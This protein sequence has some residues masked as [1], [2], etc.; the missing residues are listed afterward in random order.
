MNPWNYVLLAAFVAILACF[1]FADHRE[2]QAR[3][4]RREQ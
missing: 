1:M 2:R 3:R 4:A